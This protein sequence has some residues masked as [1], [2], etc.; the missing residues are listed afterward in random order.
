MS[1]TNS[2]GQKNYG[3][4]HLP[5][6]SWGRR[7]NNR[8]AQFSANRVRGWWGAKTSSC[9]RKQNTLS[10]TG[11]MKNSCKR[12]WPFLN[13]VGLVIY[14]SSSL[15]QFL[16]SP[17]AWKLNTSSFPRGAASCCS[18]PE[19]HAAKEITKPLDHWVQDMSSRNWALPAHS[20]PYTTLETGAL[21]ILKP[22]L[23]RPMYKPS[24]KIIPEVF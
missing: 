23:P 14:I 19:L 5:N 11:S 18:S 16:H 1:L 4:I 10:G 22:H 24:S 9:K 13:Q 12:M 2:V 8:T 20:C 15:I 3:N 6:P 7:I 17:M 21:H